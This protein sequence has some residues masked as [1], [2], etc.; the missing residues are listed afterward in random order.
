MHSELQNSTTPEVPATL[1]PTESGDRE[2]GICIVCR[3]PL[4]QHVNSVYDTRFGIDGIYEV[5][6]CGWC[7][8]EQMFPVPAPAQLKSLYESHYNFGGEKGTLYTSLRESFFS[9]FL[10][11]LWIRLDG[12]LSFHGRKGTGRLIDIGCNEGRGLQI[13]AR[14]G[15]QVEGCELNE[16][17]AA[18]ARDRG[19]IVHTHPVGEFTISAPYD[20]AVL[21][22]V[23]EHAPDPLQMLLDTREILLPNGRLWVS[24][25]NSQSWLRNVF[26]KYWINWHVPFH[27][28]QFS[29][30]TMTTLM[31]QAGFTRIEIRQVTPAVWVA[32]SIIAKMF[33][34]E[35]Q[36][37]RQL[38]NPVLVVALLSLIRFAAFPALWFQ[39]RRGRGDCLLITASK[40]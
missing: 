35:G 6:R 9:S 11:R 40:A 20:V 17:A 31:E 16:T 30:Q 4:V 21:S 10:Y 37:T 8:L 1:M 34:K 26:G 36:P 18:V 5:W 28:S 2:P 12:D 3:G 33:A 24:C 39:N 7:Q 32:M 27:I 15:F 14:N 19:F 22:N 23:L 38:R 25:P 13:Y 29:P